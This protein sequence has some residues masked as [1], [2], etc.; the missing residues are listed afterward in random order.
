MAIGIYHFHSNYSHDST[1]SIKRIADFIEKN[2]LDF[3]ILTDHETTKGSKQLK[4][5]IKR[6]CLKTIIPPAAEYS[7]EMGDII[8]VGLEDDLSK[9]KALELIKYSKMNGGTVF[10]PHPYDGHNLTDEMVSLIDVVEVFNGRSSKLNDDLSSKL[11]DKHNKPKI[12]SS[13]AHLYQNLGN[14][15]IETQGEAAFFLDSILNKTARPLQLLKSNSNDVS[16]SQL[17]KS[18]KTLDLRLFLITLF[19]YLT[20]PL[21]KY[22]PSLYQWAIKVFFK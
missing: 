9:M 14:V 21:K 11:A 12:W 3:A 1:T 17:I 8:V 10:L 15:L 16:L 2:K 18:I 6:R 20:R 13:D 19:K 4:D 7:T 5:E 22:F